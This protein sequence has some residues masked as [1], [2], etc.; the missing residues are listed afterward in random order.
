[1]KRLLIGAIAVAGGVA[2]ISL[3]DLILGIPFARFSFLMDILF[4]IS[5]SLIIYIGWESLK[6]M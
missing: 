4:L 3:S 6:E 1:M 2:V 5:A